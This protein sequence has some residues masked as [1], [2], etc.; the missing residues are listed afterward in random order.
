M[1]LTA[2]FSFNGNTIC[3]ARAFSPLIS[4]LV[5]LP[6]A[7]PFSTCTKSNQRAFCSSSSVTLN[8]SR[9]L[10]ARL[11]S[12]LTVSSLALE[13]PGSQRVSSMMGVAE[14]ISWAAPK[15]KALPPFTDSPVAAIVMV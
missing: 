12:L 9:T 6:V 11:P 14:A 4:R 10:V 7:W 3:W 8:S 5:K 1:K 13:K 15:P 2:S